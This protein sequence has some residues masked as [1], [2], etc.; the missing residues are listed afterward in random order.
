VDKHEKSQRHKD[1]KTGK[2][3]PKDKDDFA[4]FLGGIEL[5]YDEERKGF[6]VTSSQMR[7][8]RRNLS[9]TTDFDDPLNKRF[10][11]FIHSSTILALAQELKVRGEMRVVQDEREH[12]TYPESDTIINSEDVTGKDRNKFGIDRSRSS[13]HFGMRRSQPGK[14]LNSSAVRHSHYVVVSIDGPNGRTLVEAAMSF[15]QFASALISNM[16]I[17]CTVIGYW[18]INDE[19]VMLEERVHPP[20]S[21]TDR[22]KQRLEDMLANNDR[23]GEVIFN[24]IEEAVEKGR[25]GKRD[26]RELAKAMRSYIELRSCNSTFVVEQALKEITQ[27]VEQAAAS[28]AQDFKA[29]SF[30]VLNQSSFAGIF[31]D[32][33]QR[34]ELPNVEGTGEGEA[35]S[36]EDED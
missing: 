22:M 27:I 30:S 12:E 32:L 4:E 16:N 11:A 1:F 7:T 29:G 26:L 3:M 23:R 10:D 14:W 24:T 9:E 35:S 28:I 21:I 17:P 25:M 18:S 31:E 2:E 36:P 8:F 13:I 34:K 33:V 19:N 6:L 5:V 20:D 15:G